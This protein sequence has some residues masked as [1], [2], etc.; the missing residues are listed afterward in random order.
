V[1]ARAWL[2]QNAATGEVLAAHNARARVPIASI[3]KLM[4]VLVALR[5][6]KPESSVVVQPGRPVPGEA[7]MGLRAGELLTI[8]ELAEAALVHSANDAARALA[9]H[10][11]KGSERAFVD[12]MNRTARQLGMTDTQFANATGHDVAGQY[13]SARDA[14]LLARAAMRYPLV[15]RLVA[16]RSATV[17]GRRLHGWND[18]LGRFPGLIG[19]KTGHTVAAGWSQVA[20]ARGRG[21]TIYVTVLGSPTRAQRNEDLAELLAWGLARYRVVDAIDAARTYATSRAPYGRPAVRLV[22]A[23]RLRRALRVDVPLV[24]RVVAPE[25]V[26]LPVRKGERLG[27]VRVYLRG[28]LLGSRPLVAASSASAPGVGGKL[29]W[30]ATRTLE[31]A[32]E[33]VT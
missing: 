20:A 16:Q 13:S 28:K 12:V 14:T 30:Y 4:T 18:L 27:E 32:W 26:S 1:S 2:V 22:A 3:T 10:I 7:T 19:V 15:R 5:T 31:N 21:V 23:K 29:R 17:E 25:I 6:A 8:A 11:G 24:E 9:N 33:L